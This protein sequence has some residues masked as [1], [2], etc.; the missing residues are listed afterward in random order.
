M[1][2]SYVLQT[3]RDLHL[4]TD[5]GFNGYLNTY[6]LLTTEDEVSGPTGPTGAAGAAG[7]TGAQGPQGIQG[8]QGDAGADGADGAVGPT[9]PQ[10]I[11]GVQGDAGA[12]GADGADGAVGPTGPQGADGADGADGSD[13]TVTGDAATIDVTLGVVS[14]MD[15]SVSEGK[16]QSDSV[17]ASK[18]ATGAVGSNE[19]ASGSVSAAKLNADVAG[20]GIVLDGS[21]NAIE[22]DPSVVPTLAASNVFAS[23]NTFQSTLS[24][25]GPLS[26]LVAASPNYNFSITADATNASVGPVTIYEL[27]LDDN[28]ATFLE[29][30]LT[31]VHNSTAVPQVAAYKLHALAR[32]ISGTSALVSISNVQEIDGSN[33]VCDVTIDVSSNKLRVRYDTTTDDGSIAHL[34]V[35]VNVVHLD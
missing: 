6:R 22:V 12:D 2:P 10:G 27:T 25:N 3:Q 31:V 32:R 8:V 23:A 19:L 17:T 18:I 21:S 20:A 13:A 30:N 35:D 34:K 28:A 9:G 33:V 16:L 7:A 11:Q 4:V 24:V 5:S 1:D 29:G 26:Q 15:N 14:L